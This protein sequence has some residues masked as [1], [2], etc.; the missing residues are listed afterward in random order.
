[1]SSFLVDSD[2]KEV[3]ERL[4]DQT[5]EFAGKKVLLTGGR[6]F[7]GRYFTEVFA[8]PAIIRDRSGGRT[9]GIPLNDSPSSRPRW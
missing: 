3:A 7:L 2:I 6:G 9:Q 8:Y 1:M 5:R 4:G